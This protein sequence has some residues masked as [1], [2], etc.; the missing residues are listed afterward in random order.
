MQNTSD[1]TLGMGSI[2]AGA[3]FLIDPFVSVLDVIPDVIGWLLILR[4]LARLADLNGLI[5][6]SAGHFRKLVLLSVLRLLTPVFIFALSGAAEQGM[7]LLLFTF[8]LAVLDIIVLV[9]AVRKLGSGFSTLASLY[10]GT[11]ALQTVRSR[12][13]SR[14]DR[15]TRTTI[16]F[17]IFK[18]VMAGLPEWL[19]L[20]NV[21]SGEETHRLSG[22]YDYIGVFRFFCI[23]IVLAAGIVWL[24]SLFRYAGAV[25]HDADFMYTLTD[26]HALYLMKNP[27]TYSFR[28]LRRSLLLF[29]VGTVFTVTFF[30]DGMSLIPDA[31]CGVCFL[32]AAV[33]LLRYA[34]G[35]APLIGVSALYIPISVYAMIRQSKALMVLAADDGDEFTIVENA[36]R[37]ARSPEALA[38][39]Y[40]VCL[41]VLISQVCF[42]VLLWLL[43]PVLYSLID[44]YTGYSVTGASH[45]DTDALHASLKKKATWLLAGGTVVS[46]LP[47][48]YMFCLPIARNPVEKIT[49]FGD[50]IIFVSHAAMESMTFIDLVARVVFIVFFFKITN[51]IR[52]EAEYRFLMSA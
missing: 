18:E 35:T 32:I 3:C 31:L 36:A 46:L 15:M 40:R 50:F 45:S 17:L 52:S 51:E 29:G 44:R 37:L 4:G 12:T 38:D 47:A 21:Q 30:A 19:V 7:E 16:A 42:I 5:A 11:A 27:D 33:M 34:D 43:R 1:R 25:R 23:L 24:V 26:A 41:I 49:S 8:V 39:Y 10:N 6:E 28:T 48:A 2:L 22:L 13:I 20:F 14:T 9:P